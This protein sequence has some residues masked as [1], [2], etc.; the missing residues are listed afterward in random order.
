VNSTTVTSESAA[1]TAPHPL[2]SAGAAGECTSS[3]RPGSKLSASETRLP[4]T[5]V[6]LLFYLLAWG[7][8]FWAAIALPSLED[9]CCFGILGYKHQVLEHAGSPKIIFTGGSNLLFGLDGEKIEHTFKRKV[10]DMGLCIMFPLPYL[11]EE[12]KDSVHAGDLVVLSPEY[13]SLSQEFARP[14]VMADILDGYPRAIEWILRCNGCTWEE[15]GKILIHLRTLGLQKLQYCISHARQIVQHR[16][17]WSYN[18]PNPGLDVLN[19]RNLNSCGDLVWHLNRPVDKNGIEKKILIRVPRSIDG[20]TVSEIDRFANYCKS[21]GAKMVLIPPPVPHSMYLKSRS[22]IESLIADASKKLSIPVLGSAE[23]YTFPDGQIWGG[24]YHLD[25]IGRN[26]RTERVID[27]LQA[28][29]DAT[30]K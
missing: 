26:A 3:G 7:I 1:G 2:E 23:R 13:S 16:A 19:S 27:D 20:Y 17:T 24:H 29:V 8:V 11:F 15:K 12:I 5:P 14:M 9:V 25:K 22:D 28:T 30:G 6:A 4:Q 21:R 18:K 10:V